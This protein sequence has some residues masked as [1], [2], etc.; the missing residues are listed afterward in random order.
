M[1]KLASD[2]ERTI[3]KRE[4]NKWGI[5]DIYKDL[6]IV[7]KIFEKKYDQSIWKAN[8]IKY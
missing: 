7:I 4:F 5:F 8:Q 3:L 2:K 6:E 1:F